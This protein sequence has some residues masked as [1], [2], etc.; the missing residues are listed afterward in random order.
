MGNP[1]QYSI[2]TLLLVAT[3][4]GLALALA[5]SLLAFT[6]SMIMRVERDAARERVLRT[7]LE[8]SYDRRLLGDEVDSLK[9][10]HRQ[11]TRVAPPHE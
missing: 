7:G 1:F 9:T 10:L 5:L 2:R 4:L 3:A 6:N 8:S 11:Q